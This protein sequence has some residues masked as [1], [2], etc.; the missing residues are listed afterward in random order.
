[1][2]RG[3][4]PVAHEV[5]RMLRLPLDLWIVRKLGVPFQ[6]E[7]AMGAVG[8][9]G[10]IVLNPEVVR[11]SSEHFDFEPD[12][13]AVAKGIASGLPLGAMIARD[14]LMTWE[15]GAH[16]INAG[17][18]YEDNDFNQARR[19]YGLELAAPQRGQGRS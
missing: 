8:E 11:M 5:A 10:V 19:F 15:L 7:L 13:L 6:P 2:P 4:V 1:M 18:W 12:I 16:A 9:E 14:D 17:L 3:G